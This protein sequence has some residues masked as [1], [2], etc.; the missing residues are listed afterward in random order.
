[1]PKTQLDPCVYKLQRRWHSH[2][3]SQPARANARAPKKK[4]ESMSFVLRVQR[5]RTHLPVQ[6][7][8]TLILSQAH[9]GVIGDVREK[10]GAVLLQKM[11]SIW[12]FRDKPFVDFV[13]FCFEI[14][15]SWLRARL[16][17]IEIMRGVKPDWKPPTTWNDFYKE[18]S[19]FSQK[20]IDR[21]SPKVRILQLYCLTYHVF[22]ME[23]AVC[24]VDN[25]WIALLQHSRSNCIVLSTLCPITGEFMEEPT[26]FRQCRHIE[27]IGGPMAHRLNTCPICGKPA[28]GARIDGRS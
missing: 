1:M 19:L 21:I 15:K 27:C 16:P 6:S 10:R 7:V 22:P 14:Y 28:E 8:H 4:N 26:K 20:D 3:S 24:D 18:M 2:H 5:V 23:G 13:T 17:L 9:R 11:F 25:T 12:P